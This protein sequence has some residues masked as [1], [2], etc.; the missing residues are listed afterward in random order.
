MQDNIDPRLQHQHQQ[1]QQQQQRR[2]S[3]T[4]EHGLLMSET[5][6][7][8]EELPSPERS[9]LLLRSQQNI[10]HESLTLVS[11]ASYPSKPSAVFS[12]LWPDSHR[13]WFQ[14]DGC[15]GEGIPER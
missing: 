11:F 15:T 4:E 6:G 5:H 7:Q 2:Q 10:G 1:Q 8:T 12:I 14:T 13:A 3:E 9:E